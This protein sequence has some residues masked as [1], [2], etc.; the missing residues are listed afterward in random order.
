MSVLFEELNLNK[1]LLNSLNDLGYIYSTPI[2]SESF[3]VIMSGRD[4]IGVA[5][6][7]TG[8]TLAYILPLLRQLR[9]SEIRN[10]RIVIIVPTRELVQQVVNEVKKVTTYMTVRVAGIYG[11]TNINT[12]KEVVLDGLDILVATPGRLLD[13]ALSGELRF[14][15]VQKLII[16]E[17]DEMLNLGFRP[18]LMRVLDL[19]PQKKQNLMFS[20]TMNDDIEDILLEHF[21]VPEKIEIVP[22]GTPVDKI[23]QAVYHVPNFFTKV[24]LLENLL[25]SNEDMDKVLVFVAN[26]RL[27]DRLYEKISHIDAGRIGVIHSNKSQN[28]RFASVRNFESGE[29]RVLIATD[30]IARGLDIKNVSHVIN[31]DMPDEPANYIHRIGRT[32]RAEKRGE[33]ISFVN[34]VEMEYQMNIEAFMKQPVNVVEMPEDVQ[35]SDI[36]TDEERPVLYDKDYLK[37][38]K[39][40]SADSGFHEKKDKNKK[41]NLGGSYKRKIKAKYKKP[42]TR[43]QK[44]RNKR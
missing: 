36:Y 14:K 30:I 19:M 28:N 11:G 9:Y 6:T 43:G 25:T 34:E 32:G 26:K 4:V 15:S 22:T 29:L 13:I 41:V 10:P 38:V 40:R 5:Q 44:T 42:K 31:F 21:N 16:D 7:G 33:A 27:A 8:K 35:I 18:Q 20:A 24:S 39:K 2:Q 12:Q 23:N 17:V 37:P 3:P 1:Q